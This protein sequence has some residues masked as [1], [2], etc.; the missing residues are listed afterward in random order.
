MEQSVNTEDTLS[1]ACEEF[2]HAQLGDKRRT[3]RLVSMVAGLASAAAG[4]I[5]EVF[6]ESKEREA[7]YRSVENPRVDPESVGRASNA[8]CVQRCNGMPYVY[9]PVDGSSLSLKDP[10]RIR[11]LGSVGTRGKK[12]RG[13]EVM[14]AI[15]VDPDGT[16]LGLCGQRYWVRSE[17]PVNKS[18]KRK[19][20]EKETRYWLETIEQTQQA[21]AEAKTNCVPWYQLDRGG[22]FREML[23]WAVD[24]PC[25]VTVRA[26]QNRHVEDPEAT[27]LS[28]AHSSRR[29]VWHV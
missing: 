3:S 27:Y 5:S 1:W 16:P 15:A 29:T 23:A 22:D 10:K 17:T 9:V 25:F 6:T 4:K 28:R 21:F 7:A 8:A 20:E 19:F 26:A 14:N 11:G 12:G 2:G 18:K 13:L 24:A